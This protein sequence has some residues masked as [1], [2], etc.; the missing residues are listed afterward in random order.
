MKQAGFKSV[1]HDKNQQELDEAFA[2]V[3]VRAG[4]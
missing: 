4:K 2:P 1:D 3:R